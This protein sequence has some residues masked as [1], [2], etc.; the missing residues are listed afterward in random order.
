MPDPRSRGRVALAR[1]WALVLPTVIALLATSCGDSV[2]PTES[3]SPVPGPKAPISAATASTGSLRIITS[4][5]GIDLDPNGY[6]AVV[7][8]NGTL[9]P[10]D[11]KDTVVV[12]G[13][14][15]GTHS[16]YLN[17]VSS[18]C[19]GTTQLTRSFTI[20]A[21]A[22]TTVTYSF[23]CT[24]QTIAT[25]TIEI[26]T[27]TTGSNLDPDGYTYQVDSAAVREIGINTTVT[28]GKFKLGQHVV[29]LDGIAANCSLS[30]SNPRVVNVTQDAT[31]QAVFSVTCSAGGTGS[32]QASVPTTGQNLDPNG[33]TL[34][35]DGGTGQHADVN[36]SI[37]FSGL[38]AGDHSVRLTTTTVANNCSVTGPNPQTVT[39]TSGQTAQ[40]SFPIACIM[41]LNN[42]IL[43]LSTRDAGSTTE[44]Y[45][46]NPDG[47]NI[48]RLTNNTRDDQDEAVSPDGK[49]IVFARHE[50][51]TLLFHL[52]TM[53]SDGTNQ[54]RIT[55]GAFNDTDPEW[56]PDG[57][58]IAFES[59]RDGSPN[60][61]IMN[62]DGTGV[63]QITTD[64]NEN[65]D[66]DWS[67][68]GSKIVYES[69]P[70]GISSAVF[71]IN[72]DGT[73]KQNLTGSAGGGNP[74]WSVNGTQITFQSGR[75]GNP[76][77]WVMNADGSNQHA[78][79]TLKTADADPVWSQDGNRIA[80]DANSPGNYEIFTMTTA[81]TNVT[82]LTNNGAVDIVPEWT[83]PPSA[84]LA[85]RVV[86]WTGA[87]P[88]VTAAV[89]SRA[90]ARA[91]LC[92]TQP[93]AAA[94]QIRVIEP[95][96]HKLP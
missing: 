85:A 30:G 83:R 77:V 27:N 80:Y 73:G 33:Y 39:V 7:D 19:R 29:K 38:T 96:W 67:P 42:Q 14:T 40:L 61:F 3:T 44:I 71:V 66:V 10:I 4:T 63:T 79:T 26:V 65:G 52:Y 75:S 88:A 62:S 41:A 2:G 57:T 20:Q 53:N 31:V 70:P 81:G 90:A 78:L 5:A 50:G 94:C 92:S 48:K 68:D 1:A 95:D 54:V 82:R 55:N 46:M 60:V 13:L 76:D 51:S 69:H 9:Y 18:N 56:N 15:V 72:A 89:R 24:T 84:F 37:T 45:F 6:A 49:K 28:V 64:N 16:V 87:A 47:T 32:I 25:G 36:A 34:T 91:Q 22:T 93:Q 11:L 8:N 74:N 23:T 58:K 59:D 12:S 86:P 21:G 17:N 35:V 43:F